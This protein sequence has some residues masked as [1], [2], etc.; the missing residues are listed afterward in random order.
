M[1]Y[2]FSGT[3]FGSSHLLLPSVGIRCHEIVFG[4]FGSEINNINGCR[5]INQS[6][7][8]PARDGLKILCAGIEII[9]YI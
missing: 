7:F 2:R 6:N 4:A 9:L 8:C 1:L 5:I 3:P